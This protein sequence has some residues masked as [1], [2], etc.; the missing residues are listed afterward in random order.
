MSLSWRMGLSSGCLVDQLRGRGC[1]HV[2][3]GGNHCRMRCPPG[4]KKV[5]NAVAG[6][7]ETFL[8]QSRQDGYGLPKY[9]EKEFER[10]LECGILAH[11]L[12]HFHC[13]TCGTDLAVAFSCKTRG[14]CTSCLGR[15][16]ADTAAYL[17]D[18]VF[19]QVPVRQW[20]QSLPI[21]LRFHL[22]YDHQLT[23]EVLEV[24]L[25]AVGGWYSSKAREICT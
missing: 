9:V 8:E 10:Y 1:H 14:F 4:V 22:A 24:F 20:V 17:V 2:S 19:P 12:A 5:C 13:D 3:L 15:R 21:Q 7:L 23:S 6:H 11:G 25:R 16:M 18:Q